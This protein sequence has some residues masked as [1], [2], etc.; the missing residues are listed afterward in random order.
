[1]GRRL[2]TCAWSAALGAGLLL[3]A[4]AAAQS[5]QP[6]PAPAPAPEAE[7][8]EVPP[9]ADAPPADAPP[10]AETLA[11]QLAVVPGTAVLVETETQ[12]IDPVV[13]RFVGTRVA[14]EI[15]ALG[16]ELV[17]TR[18]ARDHMVELGLTYPPSVADLWRI[19]Y[20]SQAERGVFAQV[21][22]ER[23]RY[24]VRL[25]VASH[26]GR[27][28]YFAHGEAAHD[29]VEALVARLVKDSLPP[30]GEGLDDVDQAAA[31]A[32]DAR[33]GMEFF[34]TGLRPRRRIR[35]RP[36]RIAFNLEP[37]F[38]VA[39][40]GFFN[41]LVGVR[42][43]YRFSRDTSLGIS[44]A[45]ANLRGRDGRASSILTLLQIDNRV[46]VA[47]GSRVQIP[48]RGALGYLW[49]NGAVLRLATGVA[50]PLGRRTE[51][52]FDVI[53][54]TFW[55]TPEQTLFSLN[56]AAELGWKF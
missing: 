43:D 5:L 29:G 9:P 48:L 6:A 27:G 7:V 11:P 30:P 14:A 33:E 53:A 56:V 10:D 3:P 22:A 1:M 51:L 28:P 38:G 13:G 31:V 50:I 42:F 24:V 35:F 47:R 8:A 49:R 32:R 23:G 40:D 19:T 37:A 18:V 45:Y 16:Y 44:N 15:E 54:P 41:Q 55:L 46:T 20:R 25:Y 26:D 34:D 2:P 4:L 39:D 52:V 36:M 17:S 21:W 12:G